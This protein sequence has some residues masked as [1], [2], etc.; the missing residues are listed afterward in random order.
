MLGCW[1]KACAKEKLDSV[2]EMSEHSST[3]LLSSNRMRNLHSHSRL[4]LEFN[5]SISA[6]HCCFA[7][8]IFKFRVCGLL[9]CGLCNFGLGDIFCCCTLFCPSFFSWDLQKGQSGPQL[10][11][12]V[13]CSFILG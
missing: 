1:A 8:V 7:F 2:F 13:D 5:L 9:A 4:Y 12:S 3:M 6:S 11:L 10:H